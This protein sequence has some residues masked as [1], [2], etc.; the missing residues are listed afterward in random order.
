LLLHFPTLSSI[1][2]RVGARFPA[3]SRP[4]ITAHTFDPMPTRRATPLAVRLAIGGSTSIDDGTFD[5]LIKGAVPRPHLAITSGTP[6]SSIA[7]R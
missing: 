1:D 6:S 7:G 4:R 5:Q 3:I 2:D